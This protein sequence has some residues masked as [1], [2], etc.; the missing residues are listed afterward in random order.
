MHAVWYIGYWLKP[1]HP[2]L[3][4]KRFFSSLP[5]LF[6]A[7]VLTHAAG[8]FAQTSFTYQGRLS[9][10]GNAAAG[11]YDFQFQ[12]FDASTGGTALAGPITLNTVTVNNGV[13]T[14]TLDFGVTAF[15][16]SLSGGR[17]VEINARPVGGGSYTLLTPRQAVT[18]APLAIRALSADNLAGT[19]VSANIG[20]GTITSTMLAPGSVNTSNL[21]DGAVSAGKLATVLANSVAT[22]FNNPAPATAN[23]FGISI[24]AL[25]TNR[26]IVGASGAA[27]LFAANGVLLSTFSNPGPAPSGFGGRVAA[28]GEDK[29]FVAA[30]GYANSSGIAY[31]FSTNSTLL[32]TF[33]N[34]HPGNNHYFGS[35]A[36]GV[37]ADKVLIGAIYAYEVS[38]CWYSG[39][40]YLFST[41]GTLLRTFRNPGPPSLFG[42][43]FGAAVAAVGTDMV[44]IGAPYDSTAA[45]SAGVAYLFSTNG[46]LL[47]TFHKPAPAYL[48]LFGYNVLALGPDKVLIQAEQGSAAAAHAGAVYLFSTNGT[49]LAT[50]TSPR[51][52]SYDAFG[53]SMA[54]VATD[55]VLIGAVYDNGGAGSGYLFNTNGTLVSTF[56]NP[57]PAAGDVFGSAMAMVGTDQFMIGNYA[58]NHT[59]AVYA[60][61][62]GSPYVPGLI[63]SGVVDHSITALSLDSSIGVWS[64]SGTN[65]YFNGGN[66]GVG[67]TNPSATLT[68]TA[69][70]GTVGLG[71]SGDQTGGWGNPIVNIE[72][73]DTS[74]NA[75]P[76]LRVVASGNT[77]DGALNV[78]AQGTGL[79]AR[80]GN[81]YNFV[82][83]LD[84]NGNWT[85]TSFT[86]DGAGLT[87]L[88][89][90]NV[91][92]TFTSQIN[93]AAGVSLSDADLFLRPGGDGHHGLGWY[94]TG[95]TFA[96]QAPDG[97]VLYGFAGGILGT[98]SGGVNWSMKWDASGNITTR[99]TL[100]PPSD[101]N[102]KT[103]FSSI[104]PLEVLEKVSAMP[105]TR[106]EYKDSEGTQHLGPVAQDFHAAFGLG[107]D[108]K[109]IATVDAD[110]V[111]FAAIQGLN[112]KL[113][114]QVKAKDAQIE[115]LEQ[116]LA[117]LEQMVKRLSLSNPNGK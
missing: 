33:N 86:G 60:F 85:A 100:N 84:T 111:A 75:S 76:A 83:A 35:G 66:V 97:P 91:S 93:A 57:A 11:A 44:L 109:H 46:T 24:S 7:G 21:A 107:M 40:A 15:A 17:W 95:K 82:S 13:F 104:N 56:D 31:L 10:G 4:M 113:E 90:A 39:E 71:V 101:R 42:D 80:F 12:L 2:C 36:A 116:R 50:F 6:T 70:P 30:E 51:T 72:N 108:D 34:P 18:T 78:S 62:E 92:G 87:G 69:L 22:T 43:S 28:V 68:V 55:K 5:L 64:K 54:V 52:T 67:T 25:G 63:S 3:V 8:A 81:A 29:V 110:G 1:N 88:D 41:N 77:P 45:G 61:N 16:G 73:L 74:A 49:L 19:L 114:S 58:V 106:W 117:S 65:V 99:G 59:G 47:T 27:Y 105:V 53:L 98:K 115:S 112:Q 38:G 96:F 23:E 48:D 94:G 32:T 102:V 9:D 20:A 79:I 26:V 89:A 103:N 14:V 37:G